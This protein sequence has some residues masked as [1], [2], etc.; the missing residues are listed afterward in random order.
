M[1]TA[2][3]IAP[4]AAGTRRRACGG[5]RVDADQEL[6]ALGAP[7]IA[8]RVLQGFPVSSSGSRTTIGAAVG[9]RS[10]TS[11]AAASGSTSARAGHHRR[12]AGRGE[13]VS[14]AVGRPDLVHLG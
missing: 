13:R 3:A 9:G 7:D 12:R 6:L 2:M 11:S 10:Q 4:L 14:D 1:R 8:A 5:H